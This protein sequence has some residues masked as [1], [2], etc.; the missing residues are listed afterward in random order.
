M[1]KMQV[2]LKKIDSLIPY[3]KNARTHSE[4][5][6]RQLAASLKEF[7]WTNPVLVDGKNGVIAGQGRLM[8]AKSL[9]MEEA[10]VIELAGLTATQK[11]AYILAD[12]KLAELAGWDKNLLCLELND[13][14]ELDFDL[15][16]IGF[17]AGEISSMLADG[18]ILQRYTDPD[19]VPPPPVAPITR[20]G[21]V[22]LC[23]DHRVMCGDGTVA[24]NV[25]I[26]L[27]GGTVDLICTDPPYCSG[28]FQ[29]SGKSPGSVGTSAAHKMIANDT[30]STRG[31]M[32][33]L[34]SAFS[35]FG[36]KYLYAF[37]DWRMWIYLYDVAE[38]SGF[39][40]RSM[41]VWDKC[42][43]GMGRGWRAQHELVL[44]GCKQTAPFDKHASGVGNVLREKR[45]GNKN[46]TTEKPVEIIETL[47]AN[48]PFAK[49]VADM[50]NGS[51]TTL[52]ACEQLGRQYFGMEI[53]PLYVDVTICRWQNFTGKKAV[54]E[55]TGQP[56]EEI[57]IHD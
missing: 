48:V 37:T 44:W 55:S 14:Q 35:N 41:I 4:E 11:R 8:A 46:H 19:D 49:R 39:G 3:R 43:P 13:L 50:F 23:G 21:D 26:L 34:K 38:S 28:G 5:Q 9:G 31:Y 51:G 16:L 30:L 15:S 7:G 2:E 56:F 53:D 40:A 54:L 24:D 18:G 17:A 29:E 25:K 36:A 42:S 22:W 57:S 47:L 32:A 52:I 12:N 10:P 27:D 20:P 1:S 33:L 45:T 6:I